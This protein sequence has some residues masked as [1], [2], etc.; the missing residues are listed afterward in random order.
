LESHQICEYPV[1]ATTLARKLTHTSIV[2]DEDGMITVPEA[3]GLGLAI[4]P[5]TIDRYRQEVQ[6]KVNNRIA[7]ESTRR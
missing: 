4:D 6:I 2:P 1:E 3:P 5:E 7:F